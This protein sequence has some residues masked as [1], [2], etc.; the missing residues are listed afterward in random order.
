MSSRRDTVGLIAA[1]L[2]TEAI[3]GMSAVAAGGDFVRYFDA[4]RNRR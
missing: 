2:G 4:L 3:G 1:V